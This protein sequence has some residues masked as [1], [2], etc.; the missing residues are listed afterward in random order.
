MSLLRKYGREAIWNI[1]LQAW[2]LL[3]LVKSVKILLKLYVQIV[4]VYIVEK[5]YT[6]IEGSIANFVRISCL[7]IKEDSCF[8]KAIPWLISL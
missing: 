7:E 6:F 2:E 4:M 5:V 8:S 1:S 3:Q